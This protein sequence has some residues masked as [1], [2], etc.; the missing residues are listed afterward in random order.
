MNLQHLE[1]LLSVNYATFEQQAQERGYE[2]T[3]QLTDKLFAIRTRNSVKM[4]IKYIKKQATY[5]IGYGLRPDMLTILNEDIRERFDIQEERAKCTL[6]ELT[7]TTEAEI[8]SAFW[9]LVAT[10]EDIAGIVARQRGTARK[11]FTREVAEQNIFEKIAKRYRFAIDNE[12]QGMLDLARD[13][14]E[15]DSINHLITIGESVNRT[16]DNTYREHIV[17]CVMLHNHVIDLTLD[18]T[19]YT[20]VAQV[21]KQNLAI[22]LVTPQEA[23]VM[24]SDLGLKT[25]MPEGWQFGDSIFARLDAAGIKRK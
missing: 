10:V 5:L 1:Q 16:A 24:D 21:I 3:V 25:T 18:N 2:A 6:V 8:L 14:L 12:D 7:G 13:L 19:P 23:S 15:G 9:N 20:E 22:V 11:V 17:P 4:E